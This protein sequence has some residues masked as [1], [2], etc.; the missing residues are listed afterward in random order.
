[1]TN[2]YKSAEGEQAVRERYVKFL[3]RWPVPSQQLRVPT[4]QGETFVVACGEEQAPPL[5][6]LHG[7]GGNA[8]MWMGD[9]AA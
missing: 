5:G 6:L 8:A 1:M 4:P 3:S 2:I 7:S 9:V